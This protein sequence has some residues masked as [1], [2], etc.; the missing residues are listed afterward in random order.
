[1]ND[2]R[3]LVGLSG[4]VDSSV[5]A[6]LLQRAGYEVLGATLD[7][8][9][10]AASGSIG[11]AAAVAR[12]LGIPFAS[13]DFRAAFETH[14]MDRFAADY[15]A[16]RTPNPCIECNPAVKF[17]KMLEAADALGCA[18]IATGHYARAEHDPARGRWLL[19][20]GKNLQKDQSYVLYRLSQEQLSRTLLPLGAMESKGAIR[21]LAEEEGLVTARKKD[22]QDICFIPD[23]DYAAFL[24][25][26]GVALTPGDF[27][28]EAG[29]VLGRH[30]GLPCYT[31][32][33]RKGLGVG[34][35]A[36]PL[37]VLGK[38]EKSNTVLLGPEE[39]LYTSRAVIG[40]CNWIAF[41]ELT[42]PVR[43]TAKTRYSHTE[44]AATLSPLPGG[45]AE[46]LFDAP[47]RAITPGQSAVL[48]DGETVLG[49]GVICPPEGA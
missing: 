40:R 9:D 18:Y 34:G 10:G 44:A 14:V 4:G 22:S 30:K 26:R 47:Q 17:A 37:Y 27:V 31:T 42:A 35:S 13:Y 25:R 8:C 46:V 29:R 3:V 19:K 12:R 1:M 5:C 48:Y 32:G 43:C 7:L 16:G 33:Q 2:K 38:D 23:G 15:C 49:G 28:D 39:R 41:G 6:L 36:Y 20:K 11:D 24:E 45:L 21:A